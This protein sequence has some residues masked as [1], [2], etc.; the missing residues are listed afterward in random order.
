MD[1]FGITIDDPQLTT[2]VGDVVEESDGTPET[3][4]HPKANGVV[5]LA[6]PAANPSPVSTSNPTVVLVDVENPHSKKNDGNPT[7]APAT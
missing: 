1:L 2:P 5:V 4:P 6:Q 7:D 3:N